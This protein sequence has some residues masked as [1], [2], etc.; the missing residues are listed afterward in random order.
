ML[1]FSN[2][3]PWIEA[4][5]SGELGGELIEDE[6][7]ASLDVDGREDVIDEVGGGG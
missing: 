1:D 7:A 3:K 5:I 6:L 2:I 4:S